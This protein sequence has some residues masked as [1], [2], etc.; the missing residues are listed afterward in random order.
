MG[1][2]PNNFMVIVL[3]FYQVLPPHLNNNLLSLG[4]YKISLDY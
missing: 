3:S 1:N 4:S 2:G